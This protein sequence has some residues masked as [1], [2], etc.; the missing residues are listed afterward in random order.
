MLPGA[1][2]LAARARNGKIPATG[3]AHVTYRRTAAGKSRIN[4]IGL[5]AAP[6]VQ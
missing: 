3:T 4:F 6:N 1:Q 2:V 5:S